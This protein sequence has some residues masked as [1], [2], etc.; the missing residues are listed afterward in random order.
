MNLRRCAAGI[1]LAAACACAAVTERADPAS[2]APEGA[3]PQGQA[4]LQ[5]ATYAD[6]LRTWRSAAE[7]NTWIGARFAYDPAR[8]LQLSESQRARAGTLPIHAPGAFYADPR[9]VCVDL[10]RFAVETLR[11]I[12]PVA[13][14]RYVMI[15]FDPAT[16]SGQTLRLH[17]VASYRA[18]EGLYVFGDSKRP[19]HVAGPY[20]SLAQYADEYARYRGRRIVAIQERD[21]YQKTLRTPAARRT[22]TE[23]ENRQVP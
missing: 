3:R 8:A 6:A 4:V 5:P 15:E 7:I 18:A 13:G 10:A 22:R 12:D 1:A 2:D 11:A 21:S 17:W 20:T 14:A 16:L 9:G 23:K 19:G